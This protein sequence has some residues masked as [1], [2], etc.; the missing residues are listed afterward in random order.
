MIKFIEEMTL[1]AKKIRVVSKILSMKDDSLIDKIEELLQDYGADPLEEF[2]DIK[3]YVGNIEESVDIE[4]LKK[5]Q[6]V[7]K[8][9]DQKFGELVEK[10]GFDEDIDELLES[11]N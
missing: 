4:K 10:A 7:K 8:F 11:L 9:N 5:E 3:Y 1:E 2:D 6:E